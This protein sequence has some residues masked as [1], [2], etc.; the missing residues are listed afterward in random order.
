MSELKTNKI[1]PVEGN[2]DLTLGDSGDTI[3]I[4]SGATIV[5]S[6]TATG[7]GSTNASD[8][9][10]GTLPD[11]R[12]PATLPA[13]SGANLTNLPVPAVNTPMF[14][15]ANCSTQTLTSGTVTRMTGFPAA[16]TISTGTGYASSRFTCP[17]GGAG[18]Y[19]IGGNLSFHSS[20]GN[21]SQ[22]YTKFYRNGVWVFGGY[23]FSLNTS[24]SGAVHFGDQALTFLTLAVGDTVDIY[25]AAV[26]SGTIRQFSNDGGNKNFSNFWG[27]KVG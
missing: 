3:T 19:I 1:S 14:Y 25:G 27:Y 4:P 6:G 22:I 15:V 20:S 18:N 12:F 9:T 7:F 2:T 17:A 24:T 23:G 16:A 5:N 11:A 21:L 10:S 26:G 13:I 8:L